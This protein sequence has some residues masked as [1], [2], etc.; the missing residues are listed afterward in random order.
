MKGIK[1]YIFLVSVSAVFILAGCGDD[2]SD[3]KT[4]TP[5]TKG[6]LTCPDDKHPHMIDL[7]L[8]SGT[9]WA[10]CNV[11]A[12]K[13][14]AYGGYYAWGET[15]E[16]SFYNWGT[17]THCDGKENTS[18]D[19]GYIIAKTQYDVAYV[20]WGDLWS[21]PTFE[22]Q[23]ELNINCSSKLTT[24]N[25]VKGWQF[26]GSNGGTIFLPAAGSRE[27]AYITDAGRD[28]YYW[29]SI[30]YRSGIVGQNPDYAYSL[31]FAEND[32]YG[33]R[34]TPNCYGNLRYC[35]YSVRPVAR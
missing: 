24:K 8:P 5:A 14:E 2:D 29:L 15:E 9:K 34:L 1:H 20:K 12:E 22:Q 17:Y 32:S 26:T 11:G 31:H 19:L 35:G 6:Y 25:G 18:H 23:K 3:D 21:M 16:K 13:P 4:D 10:C 28:G 7:G 33:N 27:N 30:V